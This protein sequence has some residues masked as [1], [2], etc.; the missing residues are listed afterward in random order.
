MPRILRLSVNRIFK[1]LRKRLFIATL[2]IALIF[3]TADCCVCLNITRYFYK[4]S[5][6]YHSK[7]KEYVSEHTNYLYKL[8]NSANIKQFFSNL[9]HLTFQKFKLR[10][11][12]RHHP[13]SRNQALISTPSNSFLE[14][15][16]FIRVEAANINREFI[17]TSSRFVK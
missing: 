1:Q 8:L 15:T 17:F 14:I 4:I 12:L 16:I 3:L 9:T 5:A 2:F 13:H 11:H 6:V 7:K 10:D